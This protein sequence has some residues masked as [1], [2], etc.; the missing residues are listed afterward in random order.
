MD[1]LRFG[2]FLAP[3]HPTGEHPTLMFQ[4]DLDL[5]THLDRLGFDEF[6]CGE[7][8]SSGWE[9][10]ASPEMFLAAAGQVSHTIRLGTGVVSLPYHHPFNVAQRMVQLDHMTRGRAIFGSGPGALPSDARTHGIDPILLRDRQDEALG[11]IIRLLRGEDR[12]TYESEWITLRD[13]QLQLLPVQ[14]D[15]PMAVASSISPSGMQLAG[16]YGIGVL[17]IAS[18]STEGLQALPTQWAFAEEAAAKHGS[19]VDR[20]DWRVLM[21]FHLAE[22][23]EQARAEAVHGLHRWHNEY[24]VWTLGRPG[25]VAVEDPWDLLERTTQGGAEGAGAA[26]VGTPDELV[27]A[28][29]HLYD[30]TGGFGVVL[31]FA[32]DWAGREAT[33][34]S[35]DLVARYVV[36]EIN[37]L[38]AG[39]RASAQYLH[40][41]QADLMGGASRAVMAKI[42]SHDGAAKAMATTMEQMQRAR[43]DDA[44]FRPGA[45][46]P[47]ES[48]GE[49]GEGDGG[50]VADVERVD[51][52]GDGDPDLAGGGS[53]RSS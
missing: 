2:A 20:G 12:F 16:K 11:V 40:D 18:N 15:M 25:A 28:I 45:G 30:I 43:A 33:M 31:G 38:T 36:P 53:A 37:G 8:H 22:T 46:I 51:A 29:R 17:S 44:V 52:G 24:N 41:N 34:R 4:R 50:G 1:R 42:M 23:R 49:D 13:A 39:L 26:V 47:D 35:W 27:T 6:W 14:D 10:I 19:T 7:H 3:H 32:H 9:T 5:V 48:A 21:A